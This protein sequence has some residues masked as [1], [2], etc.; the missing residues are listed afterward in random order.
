M[1]L[2]TDPSSCEH[3]LLDSLPQPT[4][5]VGETYDYMAG[6]GGLLEHSLLTN[7]S[8]FGGSSFSVGQAV[9]VCKSKGRR[10]RLQK[11]FGNDDDESTKSDPATQQ[12]RTELFSRARVLE[13][14]VRNS[15]QNETDATIAIPRI[16]VQYPKGSTYAVRAD[17]LIPVMD[18]SVTDVTGPVVLAFPETAVYRRACVV[19]TGASENF[20]EI[21][22]AEGIT[23]R[24]VH[25]TGSPNRHVLGID[26]SAQSVRIANGKYPGVCAMQFVVF[27]IL[28]AVNWPLSLLEVQP[29]VVAIDINGNRELH[30]VLHCLQI[31]MD[32][33]QPRL[34]LVK[35][36][37][38]Y[39][40]LQQQF[41]L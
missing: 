6:H 26:K 9:W 23:C 17:M 5:A 16:L 21:G 8:T 41:S 39:Y 14:I 18:S 1:R 27:D 28:E 3:L 19:H 31:V 35:S 25:E 22:C 29:T 10:R 37:S 2:F 15:I 20:C 24:R 12:Q 38:L 34:I 33:W 4:A 30:P 40:G 7:V 32:R 36:R 13:T 11:D